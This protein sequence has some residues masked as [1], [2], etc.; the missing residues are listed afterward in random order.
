[1]GSC[2][3][4]PPLRPGSNETPANH[5]AVLLEAATARPPAL[6]DE[7]RPHAQEIPELQSNARDAEPGLTLSPAAAA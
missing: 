4:S 2:R 3:A 1:M 6:D 5:F 7:G